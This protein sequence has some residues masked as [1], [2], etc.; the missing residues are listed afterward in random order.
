MKEFP[1]YDWPDKVHAC[2]LGKTYD[3]LK[4]M[5]LSPIPFVN[6]IHFLNWVENREDKV[7]NKTKIKFEI[8]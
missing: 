8:S 7:S 5:G 4:E 2:G 3:G 6:H 1:M